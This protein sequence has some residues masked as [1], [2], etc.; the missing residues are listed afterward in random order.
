M[1]T[2]VIRVKFNI[3]FKSYKKV[4]YEFAGYTNFVIIMIINKFKI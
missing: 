4:P 2:F 1:L 3:K